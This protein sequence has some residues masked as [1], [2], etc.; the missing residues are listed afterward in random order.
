MV[1]T[2]AQSTQAYAMLIQDDAPSPSSQ[3]FYLN[4]D[5]LSNADFVRQHE[6]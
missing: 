2:F 6:Q 1:T 3:I 4:I 5:I